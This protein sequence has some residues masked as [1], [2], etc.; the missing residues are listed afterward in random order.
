M[1]VCVYMSPMSNTVQAHYLVVE[2]EK[3]VSNSRDIEANNRLLLTCMS[4]ELLTNSPH[5]KSP[6]SLVHVLVTVVCC[7][8]FVVGENT[9]RA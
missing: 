2:L 7:V 3:L 1:C 4:R 6:T 5:F 9:W 8:S